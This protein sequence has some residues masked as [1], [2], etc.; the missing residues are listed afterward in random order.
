M[1]AIVVGK[2]DF[3]Q[4]RGVDVLTVPT[5]DCTINPREDESLDK[6]RRKWVHCVHRRTEIERE[7]ER[8]DRTRGNF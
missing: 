6:R 3:Y 1:S 8:H 7:T 2:G 4:A 5:P